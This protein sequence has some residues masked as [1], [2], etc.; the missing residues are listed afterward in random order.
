MPTVPCPV[1]ACP[2]RFGLD[3]ALLGDGW[4]AMAGDDPAG[5]AWLEPDEAWPEDPCPLAA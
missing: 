2:C 1:L 5:R 3:G 4:A